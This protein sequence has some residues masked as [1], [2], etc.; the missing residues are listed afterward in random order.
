[1]TSRMLLCGACQVTQ[2][3]LWAQGLL[4]TVAM[5]LFGTAV[6]TCTALNDLEASTAPLTPPE[7]PSSHV[8]FD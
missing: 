5:K 1:M 2:N 3:A 7:Q 6:A 8:Q 4:V